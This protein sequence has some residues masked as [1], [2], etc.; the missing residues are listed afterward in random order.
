VELELSVTEDLVT[1]VGRDLITGHPRIKV[2]L[3]QADATEEWIP[4]LR[5][6][7]ERKR[8]GSLHLVE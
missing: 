3:A 4:W 2:Q 1:F 8:R 5:R 6:W 7:L